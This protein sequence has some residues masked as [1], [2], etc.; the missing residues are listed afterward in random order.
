V[1]RTVHVYVLAVVRPDTVSGLAVP[2]CE[3]A[4]P[5]SLVVHVAVK[6]EIALPLLAPAVKLTVNGPVVALVEPDTAFTF[7]GAAGEPTIT[8]NDATDANPAPR[9]FVARTVHVYV[10]AVVRPDTVSGLAVPVCEPATPP[11][12]DVHVAV[13]LEI[14][15]PLLAPAMK[16]TVNGPVVPVVEPDTAFTLVGAAGEPTITGNDDADCALEPTPL[17]A[18]A[19]HVYVLAVVRLDTVSGLAVPVCEPATPPSLDVHVAV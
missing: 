15:L 13:K 4:T 9:P 8:G 14:A 6:L 1:A 10:L 18:F 19:V 11:S 17:M 12:L 7:V 5:P 16:L 2:V 3:P